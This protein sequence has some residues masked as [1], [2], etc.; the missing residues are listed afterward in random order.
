MLVG[1]YSGGL[2]LYY[3]KSENTFG[4]SKKEYKSLETL[5]ITPNPAVNEV[6][7]SVKRVLKNN[8]GLMTI[9][10]TDGKIIKKYSGIEFPVRIDIS[11]IRNGIYIVSVQNEKGFSTGKL[12]I[13][14]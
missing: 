9:Q 8:T 3:G 7:I 4:I 12:V 11:G 5:I 2:G 1:N 14:R 10:A 13:C 6:S